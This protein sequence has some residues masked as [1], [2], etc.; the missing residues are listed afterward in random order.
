MVMHWND[1]TD[2]K[3]FLHVLK[4]HNVKLNYEAL[5]A[6]MGS[7]VTPKAIS[8]RISRLRT[9]AAAAEDDNTPSQKSSQTPPKPLAAQ[10]P[11]HVKGAGVVKRKKRAYKGSSKISKTIKHDDD[12]DD[13]KVTGSKKKGSGLEAPNS[14]HLGKKVKVVDGRLVVDPTDDNSDGVSEM[15]GAVKVEGGNGVLDD[16]I[17]GEAV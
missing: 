6:A 8:H 7:D 17:G 10:V 4:I 9:I 2:V 16:Q 14:A 15:G 5:A 13:D 3:L 11:D 1:K 12:D